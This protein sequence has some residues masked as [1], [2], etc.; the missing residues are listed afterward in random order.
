M[1]SKPISVTAMMMPIS[2]TPNPSSPEDAPLLRTSKGSLVDVELLVLLEDEDED[3]ELVTCFFFLRFLLLG[4]LRV[5]GCTSSNACSRSDWICVLD[6][7]MVPRGQ[8]S[9]PTH[10]FV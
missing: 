1:M 6:A 5:P 2:P 7:Q 4:I 9:N 3:D 8:D 10:D